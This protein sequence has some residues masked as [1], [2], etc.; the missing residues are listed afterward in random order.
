MVRRVGI[1]LP[2][3][4]ARF[5]GNGIRVTMPHVLA[6]RQVSLDVGA[7][8]ERGSFGT[9]VIGSTKKFKGFLSIEKL[10]R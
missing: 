5:H 1:L 3:D 8:A 10:I 2:G 6:G 7:E 9:L 4:D